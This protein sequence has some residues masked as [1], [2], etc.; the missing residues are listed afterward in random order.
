MNTL[1]IKMNLEEAMKKITTILG[2]SILA[3]SLTAVTSM[4]AGKGESGGQ[5]LRV[6]VGARGPAMGGAFSAIADDASAIYWNPSGLAQL[7]KREVSLSYNKYFEDTAAQFVAYA[8]PTEG[9]GTFAGSV[10]LMGVDDIEKRSITGGDADTADLG[11]FDTQDM[12]VTFGWANKL[13]MWGGNLNY[14]ASLKYVSSD[15][16]TDKAQTG[17]VDLGLLYHL[18]EDASGLGLSFAV[19]NL[20]GELKFKDEG[21]PLPLNLKPGAVYRCDFERWGRLN[22]AIDADMLV[23]D[24]L[25]FVQPGLEWWPREMFALRTGYQFGRDDDAGSG[26]AAGMGINVHNISIDY[27]FVPYGELGD[28]HRMSLGF[29]F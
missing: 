20:G 23:N 28:T 19:L 1:T 24:G 8:H 5:F 3:T 16:N 29:K 4:A 17:A 21:D 7:Q 11:S 10:R 18:N 13:G 27:A 22:A 6:G 15:L 26:F 14:G 12:A 9:N 25:L 2:I